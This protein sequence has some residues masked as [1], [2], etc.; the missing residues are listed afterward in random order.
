MFHHSNRS[1][2]RTTAERLLYLRPSP[3]S[4]VEVWST[5]RRCVGG[6][7][8]R[9]FRRH[10]D[11]PRRIGQ[12]RSGLSEYIRR[13]EHVLWTVIRRQSDPLHLCDAV[14]DSKSAQILKTEFKEHFRNVSRIMDCVGCEKCRLWGK[15]QVTGLGTALKLLFSYDETLDS[16]LTG[17]ES[18]LL[19]SRGE[20][21]AFVNTVHRFSESLHA[22]ESFRKLWANRDR[23]EKKELEAKLIEV[24]E[25]LAAPTIQTEEEILSSAEVEIVVEEEEEEIEIEDVVESSEEPAEPLEFA[26]SD[27]PTPSPTIPD[28]PLPSSI[29]SPSAKPNLFSQR[30]IL[31]EKWLEICRE[32]WV[33]CVEMVLGF[34]RG[35][36]VRN[37]ADRVSTEL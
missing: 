20:A 30:R 13:D 3:P 36:V 16:K 31:F 35:V 8:E 17:P 25:R 24:A 9:S 19:L 5:T 22:V 2:P 1:A 14:T 34:T 28:S 15:L 4:T 26:L 27:P 10:E 18:G 29:S 21:V 33:S 23:K 32:S 12:D 6:D 7:V 37:S 11:E